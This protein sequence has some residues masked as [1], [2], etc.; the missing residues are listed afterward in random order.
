MEGRGLDLRHRVVVEQHLR[1]TLLF[2]LCV[3]HPRLRRQ[4]LALQVP[5][6][7][8]VGVGGEQLRAD[9]D[10]LGVAPAPKLT[11][12]RAARHHRVRLRVQPRCKGAMFGRARWA[13]TWQRRTHGHH[14][15]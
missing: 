11:L 7:L 12:E 5:Y 4:S 9:R 1:H 10:A 2:H 13:P 8:V 3:V 14:R 6:G 15:H